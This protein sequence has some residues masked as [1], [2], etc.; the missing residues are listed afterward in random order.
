MAHLVLVVLAALV[1]FGV[2]AEALT[3]EKEGDNAWF[4]VLAPWWGG[5]AGAVA[6]IA[7]FVAP[8]LVVA[9]AAGLVGY[10]EVVSYE[11]HCRE[12]PFGVRPL[13]WAAGAGG[14][15]LLGAAAFSPLLWAGVCAVLALVGALVVVQ[16]ALKAAIA[17]KNVLAAE[18]R[19]L[20]AERTP[21][22]AGAPAAPEPAAEAAPVPAP[23]PAPAPA[24]APAP[25]RQFGGGTTDL[26]PRR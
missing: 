5:G 24:P 6:L 17:E 3:N 2:Y 22:A 18:N 9:A 13:L 20:L 14:I 25:K 15:G 7:A 4:G 23:R 10:R 19:R 16:F 1:G 8:A 26:L 21:R 12:A 11:Q